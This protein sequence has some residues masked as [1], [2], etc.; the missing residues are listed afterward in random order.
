MRPS[1]HITVTKLYSTPGVLIES[2][3]VNCFCSTMDRA[4]DMFHKAILWQRAIMQ[5][6]V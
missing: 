2:D 4:V 5:T 3:K 1:G 6:K